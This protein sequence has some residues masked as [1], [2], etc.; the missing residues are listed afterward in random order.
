MVVFPT[1]R[2]PR[3]IRGK[4]DVVFVSNQGQKYIRFV[5][6]QWHQSRYSILFANI[7]EAS[8]HIF[9]NHDT[10]SPVTCPD[11]INVSM[12]FVVCFRETKIR[13]F[14]LSFKHHLAKS[15]KI[16]AIWL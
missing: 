15:M 11:T 12:Q 9:Q 10:H 4:K 6:N 14:F 7:S 2:A 1:L 5:T 8:W 16:N 3:N 13:L